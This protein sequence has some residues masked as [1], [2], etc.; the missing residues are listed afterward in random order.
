MKDLEDLAANGPF[1]LKTT[2]HNCN[3]VYEFTQDEVKSL[4][5]KRKS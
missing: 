5:A 1:P 2:C 3:S 4:L